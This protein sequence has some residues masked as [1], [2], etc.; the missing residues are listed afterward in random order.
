MRTRPGADWLLAL[1]LA[2]IVWLMGYHG[3][4]LVD[5]LDAVGRRDSH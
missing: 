4:Q 1:T 2:A 5:L 3:K